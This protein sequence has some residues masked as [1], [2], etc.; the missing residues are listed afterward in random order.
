MKKLFQNPKPNMCVLAYI[1]T[2][3]LLLKLKAYLTFF[4]I[5]SIFIF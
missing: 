4:Q 3:I 2:F 5:N 1:K